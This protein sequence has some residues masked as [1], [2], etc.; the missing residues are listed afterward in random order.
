M[1]DGLAT[2]ALVASDAVKEAWESPAYRASEIAQRTVGL[3][4]RALRQ[5]GALPEAYLDAEKV[6]LLSERAAFANT[7]AMETSL[8]NAVGELDAAVAMLPRVRD[9]ARYAEVDATHAVPKRRVGGLP[10]DDA[11]VFFWIPFR[12][13][14]E[15]EQGAGAGG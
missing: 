9:P 13:A 10:R 4:L 3:E 1:A 15:L 12:A 11:R 2:L 14:S 5:G 7:R 8:D 6:L